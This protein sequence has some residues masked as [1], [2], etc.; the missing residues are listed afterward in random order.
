[1]PYKFTSTLVLIA[2]ILQCLVLAGFFV[3]AHVAIKDIP[4]AKIKAFTDGIVAEPLGPTG[5]IPKGR[6]FVTIN[7]KI[8]LLPE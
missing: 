5:N 6:D 3:K 2:I 4:N 7:G 8:F 1:M